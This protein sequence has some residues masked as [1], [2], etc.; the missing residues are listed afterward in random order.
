MGCFL[1]LYIFLSSNMNGV[2]SSP[3]WEVWTM[4]MGAGRWGLPRC[5]TAYTRANSTLENLVPWASPGRP[6]SGH[7]PRHTWGHPSLTHVGSLGTPEA[8]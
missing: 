4:G 1:F 5:K 3:L 6:S 8:L 7:V 2:I